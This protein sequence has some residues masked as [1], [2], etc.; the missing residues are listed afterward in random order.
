M[1]SVIWSVACVVALYGAGSPAAAS[2][3]GS[4]AGT[5]ASDPVEKKIEQRLHAN[6]LLKRY[7]IKASVDGNIVTLTGTVATE[8]QKARAGQLAMVTGITR[9]DNQ[10]TVDPNAA[11]RGTAGTMEDK[12]K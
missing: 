4:R 2:P 7:H 12:A 6:A 9:V 8:A 10:I 1:K 5:T 3:A 11:T